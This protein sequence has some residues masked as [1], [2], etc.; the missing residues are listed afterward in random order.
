MGVGGSR[1]GHE[2]AGGSLL[3]VDVGTSGVRAAVVRPDA[4]VTHVHHR[5]V[6]PESPGPGLVE[7]DAAAIASAVVEVAN[8]ALADGGPVAGIGIANP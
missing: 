1:A 2:G 5:T 8:A 7:V 4:T 6:L 3:V